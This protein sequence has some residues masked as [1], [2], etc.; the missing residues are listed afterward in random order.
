[1]AEEKH[2]TQDDDQ[3]LDTDIDEH[4]ADLDTDDESKKDKPEGESDD[5]SKETEL[6]VEEQLAREKARAAKYRRL[7][8]KSRNQ[9][10]ESKP[11]KD[12]K[13]QQAAPAVDVDERILQSQGMDPELLKELKVIAKMRG[14]PLLDAQKDPL[15]V[16]SKDIF[17][18]NKKQKEAS[19][20]ASRGSGSTKPKTTLATP[21]ISREEHK[22]L[23]QE[24]LNS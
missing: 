12:G 4:D 19:L 1:M 24:T 17:D 3:D 15:F 18:K 5:D 22:R 10:K 6:T 7:F 13:Q 14:V 8:Q 23:S 16:A 20:G 21:G 11:E 2:V 9:S